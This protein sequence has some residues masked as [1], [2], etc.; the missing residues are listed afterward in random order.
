[1]SDIEHRDLVI[2]TSVDIH[3]Q[4]KNLPFGRIFLTEALERAED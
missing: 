1:M 3:L 4:E 2:A